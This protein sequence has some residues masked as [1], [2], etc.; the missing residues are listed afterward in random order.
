MKKKLLLVLSLITSLSFSQQVVKKITPTQYSHLALANGNSLTNTC[1]SQ[2]IDVGNSENW[3]NVTI[4]TNTNSV[5]SKSETV[6]V[7]T[8][9]PNE[10]VGNSTFIWNTNTQSK[11]VFTL[12]NAFLSL[13]FFTKRGRGNCDA[14]TGIEGII[15]TW[16][17]PYTQ[18]DGSAIPDNTKIVFTSPTLTDL[19]TGGTLV[20]NKPMWF[21][22]YNNTWNS[23]NTNPVK[24][25]PV[26]QLE[27]WGTFLNLDN[28]HKDSKVLIYPNPSNN[29]I[30]IQSKQNSTESFEYKI[31][32]L[33]CRIVKS[34]NSK[35]NEQISIE[36]LTSG[37]Y[38]IQI[39]IES[40]QRLTK[41]FIK[42]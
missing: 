28:T 39:E 15:T 33:T 12:P 24:G 23:I 18:T 41:K 25:N 35:F 5:V 32:D 29:L 22:W 31:I 36:N 26:D 6:A 17:I 16:D 19:A 10:I 30:T 34:G 1:G 20:G 37:N 38:I 40:G 2:N 3:G 7:S 21:E 27:D 11:T 8:T 14:D 9:L 4:Y 13:S 42:Y